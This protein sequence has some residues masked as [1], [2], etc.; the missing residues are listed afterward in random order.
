MK[1][2]H[3]YRIGIGIVV[4]DIGHEGNFLKKAV[5]RRLVA[6]LLITHEVSFK[7]VEVL[8]SVLRRVLIEVKELIIARHA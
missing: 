4:V 1:R 3:N 6:L 2:H 7:L 8:F 5:E